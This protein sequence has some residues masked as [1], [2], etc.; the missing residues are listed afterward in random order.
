[1]REKL[2]ENVRVNMEYDD[3]TRSIAMTLLVIAS[4]SARISGELIDQGIFDVIEETKMR[5]S[6]SN[7]LR[8]DL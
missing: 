6:R 7:D 3:S 1:M 5:G 8:A 4:A 2:L